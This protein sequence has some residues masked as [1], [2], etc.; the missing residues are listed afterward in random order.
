M[1]IGRAQ[2]VGQKNGVTCLLIMF[3]P[4]VM[5]TKLSKIAHCLYFVLM[6][7]KYQSQFGQKDT[8]KAF[9]NFKNKQKQCVKYYFLICKS[10]Y[11]QRVFDTLYNEIKHKC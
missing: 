9:D 8:L 2:R 3:T 7:G 10:M 4:R 6:A 5:V 1:P 11:S